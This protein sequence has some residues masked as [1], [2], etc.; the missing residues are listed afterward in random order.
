MKLKQSLFAL[1]MMLLLA[2]CSSYRNVPYLQNPQ[3]VNNFGEELSLY[4]ARIMPKDLLVI[5]V[6]T[7]D[8]LVAAPFNLIVQSSISTSITATTQ[9]A[10]QQ[11]LV[12]N[13]GEINFPVLGRLKV[14][15][16]TKR[17]AENLIKE[18]LKP[19][20]VNEE[21]IVT[22]RMVNYKIAVLGEV[23]RPGMFTISN[24]KVNILE[25]LAMA[26]DMTIY[27]VRDDVKLIREREDG[28]REI[29]KLNLTNAA[30]VTSPYYYLEQNDI[31]YVKPNK[32]KA[33]NA[34]IGTTTSLWLT[35][36]SILVSVAS[37]FATIFIN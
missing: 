12:D 26:G 27:G 9:P 14:G 25:A 11:Y 22:V 29:I 30:I 28:K 31:I 18:R 32:M 16:M 35:S 4:D 17:E 6:N 13:N 3:I 19:Y 8:P 15:G 5:T 24:E 33:K 1:W 34:D 37:L 36:V 2:G 23:N 21:P 20:V 7:T 10:L